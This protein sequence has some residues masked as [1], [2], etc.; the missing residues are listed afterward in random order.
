MLLS[1]RAREL[2]KAI[3]VCIE[4]LSVDPPDPPSSDLDGRQLA[5]ADEGVDLAHADIE[6][7]CDVGESKE[8]G[9]GDGSACVFV[10]HKANLPPRRAKAR[11]VIHLPSM[12][13]G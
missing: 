2:V 3:D 7:S 12:E 10:G 13:S 9:L 6:E 8:A 5:R 1:R 11:V 4:P